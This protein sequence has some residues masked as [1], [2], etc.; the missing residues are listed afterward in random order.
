MRWVTREYVRT[1][2]AR[3]RSVWHRWFAWH[4]VVVKVHDEFDHWVWFE[5]LER[6]WSIGK[7]GGG[8]WRYRHPRARPEQFYAE[9]YG[10]A[11][12][13][14]GKQM[15]QETGMPLQECSCCAFSFSAQAMLQTLSLA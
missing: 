4:P 13:Y 11:A 12:E 6:K 10:E 1:E 15:S 8:L 5:C 7:Y 9:E 2:Q 3:R 14:F